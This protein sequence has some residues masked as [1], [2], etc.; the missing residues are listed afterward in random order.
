[1]AIRVRQESGAVQSV[2]GG[3]QL[4]EGIPFMGNAAIFTMNL[5]L[6]NAFAR[7]TA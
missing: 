7:A 5:R 2:K 6:Q 3:K 1:L 4:T